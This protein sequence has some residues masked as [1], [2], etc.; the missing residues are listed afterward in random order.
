MGGWACSRPLGA[1]RGSSKQEYRS[2]EYQ[3]RIWVGRAENA[4]ASSRR[5]ESGNL[6]E[7][8]INQLRLEVRGQRANAEFQG[9]SEVGVRKSQSQVG[10]QENQKRQ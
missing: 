6:R 10:S 1:P 2:S 9:R 3:V 8:L 7:S 5:G 4:G